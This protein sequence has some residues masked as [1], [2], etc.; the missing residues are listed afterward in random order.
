M[1]KSSGLDH[2]DVDDQ[3][4]QRKR[5]H[6]VILRVNTLSMIIHCKSQLTTECPSS[7]RNIGEKNRFLFCS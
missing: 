5:V 4:S 6:F 3:D 1:I 2:V 7:D